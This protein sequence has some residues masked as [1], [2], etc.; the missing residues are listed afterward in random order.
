MT[1]R[2]AEPG[3]STLCRYSGVSSEGSAGSG[4]ESVL[5]MAARLPCFQ[6]STLGDFAGAIFW[7]PRGYHREYSRETPARSRTKRLPRPTTLPVS[8][9]VKLWPDKQKAAGYRKSA[10]NSYIS[11]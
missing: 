4:R 1:I 5:A 8:F 10:S 3:N 11:G 6:A 7:S 9:H 2:E